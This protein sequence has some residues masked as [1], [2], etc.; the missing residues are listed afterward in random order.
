ME[1]YGL[2]SII[3]P[4]YNS[5]NYISEAIESVINQTYFNWEMIIT[6]DCSADNSC[7]IIEGYMQRDSRIRL[8]RLK[9]NSGAGIARN[10]SIAAA[11]GRYIA[12]LDSDDRWTPEKLEKQIDF[13][14]KKNYAFTFTACDLYRENGTLWGHQSVPKSISYASLLRNCAVPSSSAVYD[15]S[16]LG[17]MYMPSIRKRQDWGLWLNIIRKCKKGYGLNETLMNYLVRSN[18][19]SANKYSLLKYNYAIYNEHLGYSKLVSYVLLYCYFIPCYIFK[20]LKMKL[21]V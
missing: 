8:L 19:V 20:R 3:T 11:Q 9:E 16:V 12:F 21:N 2:V 18:S 1:D 14:V 6:D 15:S 5:A 17:K 4:C 7:E 13:M 10:N